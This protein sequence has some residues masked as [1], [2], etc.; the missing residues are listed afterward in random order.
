MEWGSWEVD[1]A[2]AVGNAANRVEF[3]DHRQVDLEAHAFGF[4]T[5]HQVVEGIEPIGCHRPVAKARCAME[6]LDCGGEVI[7]AEAL[8]NSFS[9]S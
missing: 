8:S 6:E 9:T 2:W 5:V 7:H 4:S 3:E 1:K